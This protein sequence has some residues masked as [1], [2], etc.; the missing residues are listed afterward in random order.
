MLFSLISF[1]THEDK[2]IMKNKPTNKIINCILSLVN[3]LSF[4][5]VKGTN[6]IEVD[7]GC[8]CLTC[9]EFSE[10]VVSKERQIQTEYAWT[11]HPLKTQQ[12][13]HASVTQTISTPSAK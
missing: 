7:V 9:T 11:T 1:K 3:I 10:G 12:S 5:S 13:P 4:F 2:K 8:V 6:R